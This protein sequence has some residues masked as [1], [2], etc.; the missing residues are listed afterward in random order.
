MNKMENLSKF[1][2]IKTCKLVTENVAT[3]VIT[4]GFSEKGMD[5][6]SFLKECTEL[7]PEHK[8]METCI[9]EQNFAMVVLV[10]E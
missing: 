9:T 6:L 2:T 1:G 8:I 3:I 4:D 7:F 5:V 10:K